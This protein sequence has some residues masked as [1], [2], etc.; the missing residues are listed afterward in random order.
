MKRRNQSRARSENYC[1]RSALFLFLLFALLGIA[2]PSSGFAHEES[3]DRS[4]DPGFLHI[5]PQAPAYSFRMIM[6]HLLPG[7]IKRGVGY[8]V[9][10]TLSNVWINDESTN[11]DYEMMDLH[12]SL[13]YGFDEKFGFAL[14]YD[15]QDYFGGILDGLIQEFHD[16]FNMAQ[17]DRTDASKGRTYFERFDTG[18]FTDDLTVLDNRAMSLLVQY[19]FLHGRGNLP[20]AGISGGV[21]YALKAPAGGSQEHPVDVTLALGLAK[22]LAQS[23]YSCLYLGLTQF[24]Q[25]R[26]LNLDFK[27]EVFTG[28]VGL[29]WEIN[30]RYSFLAQVFYTED[31]VK[32]YAQFGKPG[33]EL[34]LG[35][36][37]VTDSGVNLEFAIIEDIFNYGNSPDF[38]LHFALSG[39]I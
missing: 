28:M 22:R 2:L 11:L 25:T 23:W 8:V 13:T 5:R 33:T 10:T 6:P 1:L 26:V 39:R 15:Q 21:R 34:D 27:E 18:E 12:L 14:V 36:K 37:V 20:A 16:F 9:G 19:V 17:N 31:T 4:H 24:E 30:H 7:S 3:G 29:A 35:L 38:G 32:D